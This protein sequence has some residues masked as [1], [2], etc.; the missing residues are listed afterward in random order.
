MKRRH[1]LGMTAGGILLPVKPAWLSQQSFLKKIFGVTVE[2]SFFGEHWKQ[3]K[4]V[5]K[6]TDAHF[7]SWQSNKIPYN[8]IVNYDTK[9]IIKPVHGKIF[10]F[11]NLKD[12]QHLKPLPGFILECKTQSHKKGFGMIIKSGISEQE[13]KNRWNDRSVDDEPHY[14]WNKEVI[15]CDSLKVVKVLPKGA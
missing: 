4:T 7:Q 10:T 15:F 13:L 14:Y 1:F 2:R 9:D 12:I 5:Y 11:A 8:L 6:V 3:W